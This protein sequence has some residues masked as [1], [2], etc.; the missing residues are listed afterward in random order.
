MKSLF[1][2]IMVFIG[3]T[4]TEKKEGE[5]AYLAAIPQWMLLFMKKWIGVAAGLMAASLMFS[6]CSMMGNT[7][8]PVDEE[9][10]KLVQLE[11]PADG[12]DM[13][14]MTTDKGVIKFVL[15]PEYAP[16]AVDNFKKLVQEGFYNNTKVFAGINDTAFLAGATDDSGLKGKTQDG[17]MIENEYHDNLWHFGGAVSIYG[18]ET[19]WF[20][21]H[22][23]TG[24]SRFMIN[25]DIPVSEE[26]LSQMEQGGYPQAVIDAFKEKGGL[27]N[28][29]RNYAVF[30]QVIEGMD[31][32]K[33]ITKDGFDEET[34][35]PK[36]EINIIS[37]ELTTYHASGESTS[38][39]A[40]E[41]GASSQATDTGVVSSD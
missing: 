33:A 10:M 4:D 8:Q 28:F 20:N 17:K 1:S 31:V 7:A 36:A 11:A 27:P 18:N 22:K 41:S 39:A 14:V 6:G 24:D 23:E 5:T 16:N 9:N 30:G 37:I 2:V 35:L 32:V 40:T 29:T 3:V 34:Q 12:Q 13:A 21:K 15:Y 25:T 38:S 19:G 26:V